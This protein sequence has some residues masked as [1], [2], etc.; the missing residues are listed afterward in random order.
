MGRRWKKLMKW[1]RLNLD[2]VTDQREIMRVYFF[3]FWNKYQK[4]NQELGKVGQ[5]LMMK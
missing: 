1:Y 3:A 5:K 4:W 2:E